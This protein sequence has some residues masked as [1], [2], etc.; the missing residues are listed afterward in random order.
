MDTMPNEILTK[1]S[2]MKLADALNKIHFPNSLDEV[3]EA[4]KRLSFDELFMLQ[5]KGIIKKKIGRK[6]R[7]K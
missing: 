5:L 1:N 4:R 7:N 3:G 6:N 2:F